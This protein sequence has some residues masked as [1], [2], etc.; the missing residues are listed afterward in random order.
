MDLKD[1]DV[2]KKKLQGKSIGSVLNISSLYEQL[3]THENVS[4]YIVQVQ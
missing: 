4:E 3:V 2:I 1:R